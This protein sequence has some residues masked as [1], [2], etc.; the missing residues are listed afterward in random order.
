M[1]GHCRATDRQAEDQD[2]MDTPGNDGQQEQPVLSGPPLPAPVHG[3]TREDKIIYWS[4]AIA[5][6]IL[7]PLILYIAFRARTGL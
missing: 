3:L 7:T 2:Q 4:V 6:I 5:L 1:I